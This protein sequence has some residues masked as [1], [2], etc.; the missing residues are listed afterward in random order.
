[1]IATDTERR[2]PITL[3]LEEAVPVRIDWCGVRYYV[4]APPEPRAMLI[5]PRQ[6]EEPDPAMV[7]GWRIQASSAD[8]E[9]HVFD[10]T[11]CGGARWWL[12]RLDS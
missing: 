1:M 10:V 4:D 12:T 7:T 5:P 6:G 2:E 3:V 11:S 8:D 9:K